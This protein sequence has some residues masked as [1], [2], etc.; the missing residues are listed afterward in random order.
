MTKIDEGQVIKALADV[1][2]LRILNSL[3]Q[4]P[5][6]ISSLADDLGLDRTTV[7]YHLALLQSADLLESHYEILEE[8][9]SKGKA[10]HVY[11]INARKLNEIKASPLL[12]IIQE[13]LG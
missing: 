6:Y 4:K 5:K 10:A 12:K 3:A 2:R 9:H 7:A 1:N 11:S 13:S 8:P